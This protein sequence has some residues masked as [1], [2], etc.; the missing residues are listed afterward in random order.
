MLKVQAVLTMLLDLSGTPGAMPPLT[1]SRLGLTQTLTG[2]SLEEVLQ[3]WPLS[4]A[5][6]GSTHNPEALCGIVAPKPTY[7]LVSR[8]GLIHLVNSMDVPGIMTRSVHE[9][10]TVLGQA[11]YMAIP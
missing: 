3:L 1:E 9:S 10:A 4:P 7:G 8:H 5:S 11:C 6:C 2:S